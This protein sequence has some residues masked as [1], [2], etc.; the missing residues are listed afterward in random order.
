MPGPL[1]AWAV[2]RVL[3]LEAGFLPVALM[4][5]TPYAAATA[6]VPLAL[7]LLARR[8][9]AALAAGAVAAALACCVLP[10]GLPGPQPQTAPTGPRLTVM[11]VNMYYGLADPDALVR[12][13]REYG[14]DVL[15]LQELTP[16]S[17]DALSR[18]GLRAALP[19]EVAYTAS[20]PVGGA[21]YSAY[22][23]TDRGRPPTEHF[24]MPRAE[25]DVAGAPPVEVVAAHPMPPVASSAMEEWRASLR[26][27]PD[28]AP[29]GVLR[30]LAG[31]FNATHDHAEFRAL[32]ETG[33]TDAA[34]ATGDGWDPTWPSDG[35]LPGTVLDHVLV[36]R[37]AAVEDTDVHTIPGSDH[38]A[39]V[40]TLTLP[41]ASR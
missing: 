23:L 37:R 25:V 14:V 34:A 29:D 32:L 21:V 5:F 36:D 8:W 15:S 4:A 17:A 9:P 6:C 20:G 10:R 31:D 35:S 12:L 7:A 33:Y 13:V 11:T 41:A 2:V 38:R 22:P 18:G 24:A 1:G 27:L 30:I 39:V 26:E 19:H 28:A 40:T 16:Q 3:G